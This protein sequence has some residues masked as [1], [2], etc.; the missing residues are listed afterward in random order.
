ALQRP[1][2]DR[3]V[4]RPAPARVFAG[5]GADPPAHRRERVGGAGHEVRVLLAALGDELHVAAGVGRHRAAGLALDLCLPVL[6]VGETYGD[7]H[8]AYLPE[9]SAADPALGMTDVIRCRGCHPPSTT[10]T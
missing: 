7:G 6:E 4:D 1:D 10:P 5:G 8:R 2:R 9:G 3:R